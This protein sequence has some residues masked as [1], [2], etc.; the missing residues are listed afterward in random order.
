MAR[1]EK[2]FSLAPRLIEKSIGVILIQ[3]NEAHSNKWPIGK[4]HC[5]SIQKSFKER[6]DRANDFLTKYECPFPI[7][8]DDWSNNFELRF[9][10]WPDKYYLVN[11]QKIVVAKSEYGVAGDNDGVITKDCTVLLEELL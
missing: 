8:V 3:I 10:A 9:R 11:D 5:P 6:L 1:R 4:E 7:Y 2:L